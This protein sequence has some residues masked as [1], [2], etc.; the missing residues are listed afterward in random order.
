M[1]LLG[2][3]ELLVDRATKEGTKM[4]PTV[5]RMLRDNGKIGSYFPIKCEQ[6]PETI[7]HVYES[8]QFT[9][10]APDGGCAEPCG[11]LLPKCGHVCSFKVTFAK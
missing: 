7:A 4:W 9:E 6:H 5:I 11:V 1:F 3:A 10:F 8:S 2:N